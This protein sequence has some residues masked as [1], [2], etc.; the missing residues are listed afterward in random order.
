M[1]QDKQREGNIGKVPTIP[2]SNP[3]RFVHLP[4]FDPTRRLRAAVSGRVL[5][6][7]APSLRALPGEVVLQVERI[8]HVPAACEWMRLSSRFPK[9]PWEIVRG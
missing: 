6:Q 9:K 4:M 3:C 1:K 8:L 2:A 7:L 5:D